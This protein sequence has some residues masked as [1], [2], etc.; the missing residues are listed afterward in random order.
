MMV[1]HYCRGGR[2]LP[3][4]CC[5]PTRHILAADE[6]GATVYALE[7]YSGSGSD[8]ARAL[9]KGSG[10]EEEEEKKRNHKAEY[11]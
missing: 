8:A 10:R 7:I 6:E 2:S 11:G 5:N 3:P 1:R 4:L 9:I